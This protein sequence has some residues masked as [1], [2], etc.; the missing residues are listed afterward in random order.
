MDICQVDSHLINGKILSYEMSTGIE[1]NVYAF[2]IMFLKQILSLFIY[3][4][5]GYLCPVF[6]SPFY[7]CE[8]VNLL[9]N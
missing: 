1:R 9:L 6:C 5:Q 4:I 8:H 2:I 3:C 7:A